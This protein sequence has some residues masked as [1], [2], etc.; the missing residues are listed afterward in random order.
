MESKNEI[1]ILDR[2]FNYEPLD[3]SDDYDAKVEDEKFRKI[4]FSFESVSFCEKGFPVK[5]KD[6]EPHQCSKPVPCSDE[7]FDF[8][9][10]VMQRWTISTIPLTQGDLVTPINNITGQ[11]IEWLLEFARPGS[12]VGVDFS[13]SDDGKHLFLYDK[14]G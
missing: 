1:L 12:C 10:H 8:S 7:K 6:W 4:K 5:T 11:H 13:V 2:Y 9:K 3:G 14:E